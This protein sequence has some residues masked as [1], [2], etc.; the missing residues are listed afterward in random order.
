MMISD[1]ENPRKILIVDDDPH[2]PRVLKM[3]LEREGYDVTTAVNGEQG[4]E[5]FRAGSFDLVMTDQ[6][7]PKMTGIEFAKKMR[8]VQPEPTI[9]VIFLTGT[10]REEELDFFD[11]LENAHRIPKP[12]STKLV[13]K[14]INSLFDGTYRADEEEGE[15][16]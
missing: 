15:D 8:E 6:M 14:L 3:R 7:M 1:D 11:S 12:P 9:P 4:L 13:L 16:E 5:L 2:I 10:M